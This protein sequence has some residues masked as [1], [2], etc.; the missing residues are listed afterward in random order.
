MKAVW[1]GAV[2][3]ESEDAIIIEG[4]EYFPAASVHREY[5]VP[6]DT[7][8]TSELR[9]VCTYF[10][11]MVEGEEN[12]DSAWT[13]ENPPQSAI[14]EVGKDFTDYMAFWRGV[15]IRS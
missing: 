10:S 12:K 13:Y 1:N 15:E 9:G 11:L 7:L 8:Y 3:A 6:S 14:A 5:L 4:S 2:I